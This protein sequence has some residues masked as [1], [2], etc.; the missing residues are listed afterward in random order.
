[1][2]VDAAVAAAVDVASALEI[3]EVGPVRGDGPQ[4][5]DVAPQRTTAVP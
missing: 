1:M 2:F 5:V 4:L 3:R